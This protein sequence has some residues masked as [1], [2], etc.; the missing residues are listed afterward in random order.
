M[1]NY[2]GDNHA[3]TLDSLL[4]TPFQ[5]VCRYRLHLEA[6]MKYTNNDHKDYKMILQAHEDILKKIDDLNSRTRKAET[7]KLTREYLEKLNLL[8][9]APNRMFV[10]KD[11][12]KI[13]EDKDGQFEPQ[14]LYFFN[15]DLLVSRKEG[16]ILKD[17]VKSY[18][19]RKNHVLSTVEG[20]DILNITIY[21]RQKEQTLSVTFN[22]RYIRDQWHDALNHFAHHNNSRFLNR[23]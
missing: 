10:R 12:V 13:K 5:R 15:P 14:E 18:T 2:Y 8:E 20:E 21:K 4:S 23:R 19:L 3:M 16:L 6:L 1:R 9:E 11:D 17:S 7:S 22:S